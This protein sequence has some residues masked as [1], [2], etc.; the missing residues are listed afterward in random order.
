MPN[1]AAP[2]LGRAK[3]QN[4]H[5]T[6][7]GPGVSPEEIARAKSPPKT[8]PKNATMIG[9]A[10]TPTTPR[11]K[12]PAAAKLRSEPAPAKSAAESGRPP[13]ARH[14]TPQNSSSASVRAVQSVPVSQS[15]EGAARAKPA[16]AR[17]PNPAEQ[18]HAEAQTPLARATPNRKSPAPAPDPARMVQVIPEVIATVVDTTEKHNART[19][20]H[21][22]L[23]GDPMAPQPSTA[24]RINRPRPFAPDESE[25]EQ[26]NYIL[27]YWAVCVAVVAAVSALAFRLF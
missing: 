11:S 8:N 2:A 3:A 23:P 21:D 14:T 12:P 17:A 19:V 6:M 25:E 24:S 20:P 13:V 4:P 7:M 9:V 27:L 5:A 22:Y 1:I 26:G 10:L 16:A 15:L 18:A